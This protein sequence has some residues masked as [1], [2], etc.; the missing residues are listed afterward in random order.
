MEE[1]KPKLSFDDL[2]N[3]LDERGISNKFHTKEQI[4]EIFSERN[5]Y[6]RLIS[7][8][9]NYRKNTKSNKYIGLDFKALED[10][11]SIDTYLREYLLHLCLDIEHLLK[12]KLM[13]HITFNS[14]EDGYNLVSDFEKLF[15]EQFNKSKMQFEKNNYKKD[16]FQ[17]RTITSVWVF[18]EIIDFGTLIKFI[19][20]YTEKYPEFESII[21]Y[22]HLY[23]IKNIRNACAH[24]DVFLINLFHPTSEMKYRNPVV[25]SFASL[26]NIEN[27][28][29]IYNKINDIVMLHFLHNKFSSSSLRN[30][31]IKEGQ[32]VLERFKNNIFI[33]THSSDV[34]QFLKIFSKCV[35]Y[36][37]Q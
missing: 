8:R 6:Y 21:K 31:R 15:P 4:I 18:L 27:K 26:M 30:R 33:H 5:Y 3:K 7:Y 19:R 12:T 37:T 10:L 9:K 36:H 35:D 13:T 20:F 22:K 11:A 17:K 1:N 2:F 28:Y 14:S 34:H 32:L 29:L 23:F 25:V 24:N 16:M